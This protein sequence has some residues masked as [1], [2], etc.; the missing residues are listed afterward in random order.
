MMKN[1]IRESIKACSVCALAFFTGCNVFFWQDAKSWSSGSWIEND[2]YIEI[3]SE[4]ERKISWFPLNQNAIVRN[5]ETTLLL[6][7]INGSDVR[8]IRLAHFSGW[9]LNNSLFIAGN[10][11]LLIN[12]KDDTLGGWNRELISVEFDAAK[13]KSG[14]LAEMPAQARTILKPDL[15]LLAAVPSPDSKTL[16]VL[17]TDA[18]M[19]KNTGTLHIDF[20]AFPGD[21]KSARRTTINWSGVPGLPEISWSKDSR[22]LFLRQE[23]GVVS[24]APGQA[25]VPAVSFPRC[26]L[27]TNSGNMASNTGLMFLRNGPDGII[28]LKKADESTVFENIPYISDIREIGAGCP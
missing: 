14:E 23:R 21:M 5:Y 12:G 22:Q 17:L 15:Y 9:T 3:Q 2:V 10:R 1:N 11:I 6:H 16:A 27:S 19:E 25:A 13:A 7:R 28:E 8:T 18:T 26:F 20:Y 24:I 4:F